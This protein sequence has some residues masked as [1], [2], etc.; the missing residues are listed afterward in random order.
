MIRC[1]P[2]SRRT[3][4]YSSISNTL[5]TTF[6]RLD[7]SS[8]DRHKAHENGN[9][10]CRG[11]HLCLYPHRLLGN[12]EVGALQLCGHSRHGLCR[13]IHEII[14][15]GRQKWRLNVIRTKALPCLG[16]RSAVG[17]GRSPAQYKKE[18]P[19]YRCDKLDAVHSNLESCSLMPV[20]DSC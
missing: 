13:S 6:T 20:L 4:T 11:R 12:H 10:E 8:C 5:L 14:L 15:H 19:W 1:E 7:L 18:W 9:Y 2:H 16:T 3:Q 17:C